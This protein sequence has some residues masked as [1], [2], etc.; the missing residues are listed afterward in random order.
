MNCCSCEYF[1]IWKGSGYCNYWKKCVSGS[2]KCQ[3]HT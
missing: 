3:K 2:D 1:E